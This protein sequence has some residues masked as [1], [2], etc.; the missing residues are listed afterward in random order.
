MTRKKP[1]KK[2][3]SSKDETFERPSKRIGRK[4]NKE[5]REEEVERQK[6]QG[7]EMS[8]GRNAR[9]RPPKGGSVRIVE[10]S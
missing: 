10:S 3:G 8:I 7:S 5:T 4:S 9:T 1:P 2:Y 6:I